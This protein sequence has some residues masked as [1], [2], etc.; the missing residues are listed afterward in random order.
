[1]GNIP[2]VRKLCKKLSRFSY[3][4]YLVHSILFVIIF[5]LT[6]PQGL[7]MQCVVGMGGMTVALVVAYIYNIII[8]GANSKIKKPS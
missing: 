8:K 5:N 7:V 3:E 6:K 1:M 4:F 2:I